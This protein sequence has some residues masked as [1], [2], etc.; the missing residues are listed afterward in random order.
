MRRTL[1]RARRLHA[2]A[3]GKVTITPLRERYPSASFEEEAEGK[4]TMNTK[5]LEGALCKVCDEESQRIVFW[6]DAQ[7]E[8][9]RDADSLFFIVSG[10]E[11]DVQVL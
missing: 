11:G 8:F 5:Q 6:N 4:I 7:Q 1:F 2:D 10:L 9:D 3:R